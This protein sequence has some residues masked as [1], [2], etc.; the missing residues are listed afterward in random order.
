MERFKNVKIGDR[1]WDIVF[2]KGRVIDTFQSLSL[3]DGHPFTLFQVQFLPVGY[4]ATYNL[5]GVPIFENIGAQAQCKTKTL[6]RSKTNLQ[7][8][9]KCFIETVNEQEE[10]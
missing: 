3:V 10:D 1:V 7:K 5:F 4:T 8:L 6:F 9:T 2:G